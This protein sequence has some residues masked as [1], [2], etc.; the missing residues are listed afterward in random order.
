MFFSNAPFCLGVDESPFVTAS[1]RLK[2][3]FAFEPGRLRDPLASLSPSVGVGQFVVCRPSSLPVGPAR[4]PVT[5]VCAIPCGVCQRSSASRF[6]LRPC[7]LV[8]SLPGLRP[9]C[10][11]GVDQLT[12]W[13]GSVGVGSP[14]ARSRHDCA[15]APFQSR[16]FGVRHSK[17]EDSLSEVWRTAVGGTEHT[18][19]RI[20]PRVGQ[21]SENVSQSPNKEP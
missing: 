4:L 13:S 11:L 21:V 8:A 20:V 12:S 10:A 15:D 18:P 19:F 17:N 2:P 5:S 3:M 1:V 14:F 9:S 16:E 7:V 6:R